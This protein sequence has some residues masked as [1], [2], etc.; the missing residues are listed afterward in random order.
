MVVPYDDLEWVSS[1]ISTIPTNDVSSKDKSDSWE[2]RL[3]IV[4]GDPA[5][6]SEDSG[7]FSTA[8]G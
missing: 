3:S 1:P 7:V 8:L 5:L 2:G 6:W 4:C